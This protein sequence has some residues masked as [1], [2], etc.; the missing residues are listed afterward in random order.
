MIGVQV[1][2]VRPIRSVKH[3]LGPVDAS[4]LITKVSSGQFAILRLFGPDPPAAEQLL[5][6]SRVRGL[7]AAFLVTEP[8]PGPRDRDIP[9]IGEFFAAVSDVQALLRQVRS[10]ETLC[11]PSAASMSVEV[12]EMMIQDSREERVFGLEL[13]LTLSKIAVVDRL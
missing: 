10:L 11:C 4:F 12:I 9:G 7:C 8:E 6:Q 1:C 5:P 3:K 2:K 13:R